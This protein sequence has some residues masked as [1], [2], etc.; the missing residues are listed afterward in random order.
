[1]N[2]TTI[3]KSLLAIVVI[4]L[5][6]MCKAETKTVETTIETKPKDGVGVNVKIDSSMV[7]HTR[8]IDLQYVSLPQLHRW[9]VISNSLLKLNNNPSGFVVTDTIS[10]VHPNG[11]SYMSMS[12]YTKSNEETIDYKMFYEKVKSSYP[13]TDYSYTK[14]NV[15]E[16]SMYEIKLSN[17]K[18]YNY[19]LVIPKGNELISI[20]LQA[21]DDGYDEEIE[22]FIQQIPGLVKI[23]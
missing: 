20:D 23:H 6:T 9:S 3:Y 10:W 8:T 19:K 7:D 16:L 15:D 12:H 22:K 4:G 21:Y 2:T 11:K 17:D 14:Y 1:M 5:F 18:T 13:Y